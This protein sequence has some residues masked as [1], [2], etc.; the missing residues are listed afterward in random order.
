LQHELNRTPLSF[1]RPKIGG[2]E[3]K[4]KWRQI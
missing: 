4:R 3:G 2:K 1:E